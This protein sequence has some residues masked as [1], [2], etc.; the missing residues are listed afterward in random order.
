MFDLKVDPDLRLQPIGRV[1]QIAAGFSRFARADRLE[2]RGL[3]P[4][5]APLIFRAE[6]AVGA[7]LISQIF[8]F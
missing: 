5:R 6:L 4:Q 2:D 3:W 8:K 7:G 1:D